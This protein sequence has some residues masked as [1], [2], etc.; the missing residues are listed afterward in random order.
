MYLNCVNFSYFKFYVLWITHKWH[1]EFTTLKL[2]ENNICFYLF[3]LN[4]FP[5]TVIVFAYLLFRKNMIEKLFLFSHLS[6]SFSYRKYRFSLKETI[7][8]CYI[9]LP[10]FDMKFMISF[11]FSHDNVYFFKRYILT[12]KRR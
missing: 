5:S 4:F 6:R 10:E 8:I 11:S 1:N 9:L 7:I 2:K 12:V 3:L